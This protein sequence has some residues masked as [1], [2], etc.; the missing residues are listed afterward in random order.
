MVGTN[1]FRLFWKIS[2][3]IGSGSCSIGVV[4]EVR[5]GFMRIQSAKIHRMDL[6]FETRENC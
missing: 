2:L 4:S 3:E 1:C 6:A 5:K